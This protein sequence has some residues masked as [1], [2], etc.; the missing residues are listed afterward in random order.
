MQ[1]TSINDA[2]QQSV[3]A[4]PEDA[5]GNPSTNF[6]TVTWVAADPTIITV[7]VTSGDTL[8]ANIVPLKPGSTTVAVTGHSSTGGAAFTSSFQVTVT[9]NLATQFNFVFAPPVPLT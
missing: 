3:T 4:E 9:N 8:T 5:S 6:D 7:T 1:Q 2:Q